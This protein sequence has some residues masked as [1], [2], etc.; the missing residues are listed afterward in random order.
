MKMGPRLRTVLA[1]GRGAM[2]G[3]GFWLFVGCD[4]T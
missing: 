3:L 4:G 2:L 1:T